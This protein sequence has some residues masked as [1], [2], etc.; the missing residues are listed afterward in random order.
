MRYTIGTDGRWTTG[1]VFTT[2]DDKI[3][4]ASHGADH[5]YSLA[6]VERSKKY[7]A[8]AEDAGSSAD[9]LGEGGYILSESSRGTEYNDG[10]I[11]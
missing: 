3:V 7:D 11:L 10:I 6:K 9:L 1:S 5:N 2:N 8:S 4:V